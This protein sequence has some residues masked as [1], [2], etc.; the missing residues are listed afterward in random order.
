[1]QNVL[2][3]QNKNPVWNEGKATCIL[4]HP[5]KRY[6]PKNGAYFLFIVY[7]PKIVH[8]IPC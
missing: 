6:C 7:W 2:Q 3:L 1:M 8:L 5:S 4:I